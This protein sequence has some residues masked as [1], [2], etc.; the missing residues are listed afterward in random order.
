ML[1]FYA[2]EGP[3]LDATYNSGKMWRGA[4]RGPDVTM[5]FD[6]RWGADYQCDNQN[7]PECLND[8]FMAIVYD[9]PHYMNSGNADE[10]RRYG[11]A[12]QGKGYSTSFLYPGFISS[13]SRVLSKNG[14]VIA[15]LIDCVHNHTHFPNHST[16][17]QLGLTQGFS[18]RDLIVK[19]RSAPTLPGRWK[20]QHHARKRHCFFIILEKK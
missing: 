11:V 2:P 8:K 16:F 17:I 10:H 4:G 14:V 6:P 13:A 5:D 12:L 3:V 19:T 15:K 18:F 7:M 1:N 9:P 20:T